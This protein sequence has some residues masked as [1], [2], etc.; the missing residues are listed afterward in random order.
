M[1]PTDTQTDLPVHLE[2]AAGRE[3]PEVR[4]FHGVCG[5]KCDAA[6]VDS[7]CVGG[8]GGWAEEREVPFVEV[9]FGEGGGVEGWVGVF[10]GAGE[11]LGFFEEATDGWGGC[12]VYAITELLDCIL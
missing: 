4:R 11:F 10:G 1:K 7:A 3:E 12:H 2:A 9:V 6:V 5:W 8:G